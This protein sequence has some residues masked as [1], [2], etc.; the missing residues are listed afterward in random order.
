[1]TSECVAY[2]QPVAVL[3]LGMVRVMLH[4]RAGKSCMTT[5][6]QNNDWLDNKCLVSNMS[7]FVPDHGCFVWPVS[8]INQANH[9]VGESAAC[10]P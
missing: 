3:I 4:V 9:A 10:G 7:V 2:T 1:M 8:P 5:S 6:R